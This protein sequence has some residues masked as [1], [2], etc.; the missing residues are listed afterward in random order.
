ML[1]VSGIVGGLA[2]GL[3]ALAGFFTAKALRSNSPLKGA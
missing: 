1:L 3:S 2:A